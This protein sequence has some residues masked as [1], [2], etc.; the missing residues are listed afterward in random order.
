MNTPSKSYPLQRRMAPGS[1]DKENSGYMLLKSP[2]CPFLSP[3]KISNENSLLPP[4]FQSLLSGDILSDQVSNSLSAGS[5]FRFPVHL[6]HKNNV[7]RQGTPSRLCSPFSLS[8]NCRTPKA[9]SHEGILPLT[10]HDSNTNKRV[11]DPTILEEDSPVIKRNRLLDNSTLKDRNSFVISPMVRH[12]TTLHD[13]GFNPVS[14]RPKLYRSFSEAV[15]A[16]SAVDRSNLDPN[17][18]GD[19][20]RPCILPLTLGKHVDLKSISCD[21]LAK[22]MNGDFSQDIKSFTIID[23]RYPYEYE[24]GHIRGARNIYSEEEIVKQFVDVKKKFSSNSNTSSVDSKH[25]VL[26]FHCEFSSERGPKLCRFLRKQD[27]QNNLYP[28]LHYP[29]TYLLHGGYKAFFE[30]YRTLCEPCS[31]LPMVHPDHEDE[32]RH[33][34]SKSKTWSAGQPSG[35]RGSL[36]SSFRRLGFS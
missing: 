36:K 14:S 29:E 21:T 11:A 22:L 23:C 1:A 16:K 6:N 28:D 18:I 10:P 34:R 33:F 7:E 2:A 30:K 26:I 20:S 4:D 17:L 24:G 19:Y 13:Y 25:H 9:L 12:K 5:E 3:A 35:S 8:T 31:Y 15:D 32:L 27:R